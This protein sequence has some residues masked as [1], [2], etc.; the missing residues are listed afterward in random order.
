MWRRRVLN[1]VLTFVGC[2][3]I[4]TQFVWALSAVRACSGPALPVHRITALQA[5]HSWSQHFQE[6]GVSEPDL[7]SRYITA[8]VLGAK[9]E[10][11]EIVLSDLREKTESLSAVE[12][13]CGSGAISLSLLKS[14]PQLKAVA[15]DQSADAVS[16][17]KENALSLGLEDRLQLY[18]LD[19][20]KDAE[21]VLKCCGGVPALV[22]NPPYLY[23][24][25]MSSLQP[26]VQ[27]FEDAAALDGGADGLTAIRQVLSLASQILLNHG[28]LYLEVDPRHPPLIRRWVESHL[29]TLHY[30]QTKHDFNN[31]PR[32]CIL[33][34]EETN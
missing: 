22:S 2:R 27:R 29:E 11:V 28:R 15:L 13:G 31:R 21:T 30:V 5:V 33:Q 14:L 17:T 7:S 19:I 25:D 12:V 24:E 26:E 6:E 34:K 4:K 10:L 3:N 9:T 20:F 16:L 1:E 23:T 32:F 8:H 18:H